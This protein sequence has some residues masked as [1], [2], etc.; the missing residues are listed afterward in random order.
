M[1]IIP[2]LDIKQGQVVRGVAGRR[3]EYRAVVSRLTTA[4]DAVGVAQAMRG[5]FG[6]DTVYMADLDALAGDSPALGV[7]EALAAAGFAL[8]VDAGLREMQDASPLVRLGV[9]G[10][11][12]GFESL[13][14][15]K[16]LGQ[17]VK[18]V[19]SERLLFSL[20][21][22]AG[23]LFGPAERWGTAEPREVARRAI[24]AGVRQIIILDLARV[25]MNNGIGTE[26]LCRDLHKSYAHVEL[27]AGGGIRGVDDIQ[28]LADCGVQAVL[29]ASA[30]HD[31]RITPADYEALR[32]KD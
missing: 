13:A 25:G 24:E 2:V 29:V 6:F 9:T 19:P 20:D 16:V 12:A 15:P 5:H 11:V 4:T 32:T 18:S 22:K 23:R 31:G 14:G 30:L 26:A 8:W 21:L 10:I 17:L 3:V 28:R 7:Y 1:R 27:I